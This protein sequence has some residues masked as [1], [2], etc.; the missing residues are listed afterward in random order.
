[1][2]KRSLLLLPIAL[3]GCECEDP[4]LTTRVCRYVVEPTDLDFGEI[5]VGQ[6]RTLSFKVINTGNTALSDFDIRWRDGTSPIVQQQFSAPP[7]AVDVIGSGQEAEFSIT[8]GPRIG[9][10]GGGAGHAATIAIDHPDINAD[11]LCP[12]PTG[13]LVM[14][15][16]FEQVEPPDAGQ[17]PVDGGSSSRPDAG[18][19]DAGRPDFGP[20]RRFDGGFPIYEDGHFQ[21]QFAGQ[22]ARSQAGSLQLPDGRL[23][24]AGGLN[25]R[26]QA[27]RTL[28]VFDPNNG[29]PSWHGP[30][31]VG[32]I[33]PALA[34]LPDG[35]VLISGGLTSPIP[36][37]AETSGSLEIFDPTDGSINAIGAMN[38]GR[39]GH[40][41]ST[42][43]DG[44]VVFIG[45][46]TITEFGGEPE[47]AQAVE[48]YDPNLGQAVGLEIASGPRWDHSA[49]VFDN[50]QLLVLGGWTLGEPEEEGDPPPVVVARGGEVFSGQ[51]IVPLQVAMLFPRVHHGVNLIDDNGTQRLMISGGHSEENVHVAVEIFTPGGAPGLGTMEAGTDMPDARYGHAAVTLDDGTILVAG[52]ADRIYDPE[53]GPI[54]ARRDAHRYV[55]LIDQWLPLANQMSSRRV[56]GHVGFLDEGCFFVGGDSLVGRPTPHTNAERF[57]IDSARF[58]PYGLLGPR[59]GIVITGEDALFFGGLELATGRIT[60]RVRSLRAAFNDLMPMAVERADAAVVALQDGTYLVIG[61][62]DDQGEALSSVEIW[63]P[64]TGGELT[65]ALHQGRSDHAAYLLDNG[66]VLVA[67]GLTNQA[68]PTDG[69]ELYDPFTGTWEVLEGRLVTGR[70]RPSLTAL[71][72]GRVL[73][74]GGTDPRLGAR[75][76]DLFDPSDNSVVQGSTPDEARRHHGHL[77]V[78]IGESLNVLFAGGEVFA[79]GYRATDSADLYNLTTGNFL[80]LTLRVERRGPA[81]V[82][83]GEGAVLIAG[84][85]DDT[86]QN[87]NRPLVAL[88]SAEILTL[89]TL[90]SQLMVPFMTMPRAFPTPISGQLD[91]AQVGYIAGGLVYDGRTD[92]DQYVV[93]PLTGIEFSAEGPP[94]WQE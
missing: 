39:F 50:G 18:F 56:H 17:P 25:R 80:P 1:M 63:N 16:S 26:S 51:A 81:V 31:E 45:G 83:L 30:M 62:R 79:G 73:L 90:D 41:A 28:E 32:R 88:D 82:S 64:E 86:P 33:Q 53:S 65:G 46:R 49:T 37:R 69:L 13:V 9:V 57:L 40:S 74:H 6:T 38:V 47:P 20:P 11:V 55:G 77:P 61:G 15:R 48:V 29:S 76:V 91:D 71:G 14:G 84:G 70:Y 66:K 93:T 2:L 72:D 3:L 35:R 92:E 34:L 43:P 68:D 67:G 89:E 5:P 78:R 12:D 4:N 59:H 85:N 58:D 7:Q 42:L 60:N 10:G 54:A 19:R 52:G 75:P 8:Y 27:D 36:A 94:P 23:V 21:A 22:Q 44:R 87:L 24:I